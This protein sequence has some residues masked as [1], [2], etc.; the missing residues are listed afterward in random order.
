MPENSPAYQQ[1]VDR[2]HQHARA[3]Y[4]E[5]GDSARASRPTHTELMEDYRA[6]CEFTAQCILDPEGM[7]REPDLL[8]YRDHPRIE[9]GTPVPFTSLI[10]DLAFSLDGYLMVNENEL[11]KLVSGILS[12]QLSQQVS[13]V[14]PGELLAAVAEDT[15]AEV[16]VNHWYANVSR[17]EAAEF[18]F[19][20]SKNI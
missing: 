18:L 9:N 6:I 13:Y 5:D 10:W 14:C 3:I 11:V 17:E 4:Q 1:I 2:Y 20:E 16:A 8:V 12:T 19:A 15:P 7:T